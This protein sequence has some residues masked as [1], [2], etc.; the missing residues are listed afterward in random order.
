[1][2]CIIVF[3]ATFT[4]SII[5]TDGFKPTV[6]KAETIAINNTD[7]ITDYSNAKNWLTA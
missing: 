3:I 6:V 1:M 2:V 7:E 4:G 5:G